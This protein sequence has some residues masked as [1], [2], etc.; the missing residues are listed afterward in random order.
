M[1]VPIGPGGAEKAAEDAHLRVGE[2]VVMAQPVRGGVHHRRHGAD[3]ERH[4]EAGKHRGRKL[5]PVIEVKARS[6]VSLRP[7]SSPGRCRCG[8]PSS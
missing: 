3:D 8:G 4:Q 6:V 1:K 7:S 2:K 5:K